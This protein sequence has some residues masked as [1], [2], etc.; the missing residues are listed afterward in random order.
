[1]G[2]VFRLLA[3]LLIGSFV[4]CLVLHKLTGE[5]VWRQRATQVLKWGVV[6]ALSFLGLL[7]LRRGAMFI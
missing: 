1:M 6:L 2:A 3:L 7:V 4:V 5:P